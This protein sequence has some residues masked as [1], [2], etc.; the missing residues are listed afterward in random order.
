ML[1]MC[2][3]CSTSHNY[4]IRWNKALIFTSIISVAEFLRCNEKPIRRALKADG[5][6]KQTKI[7][8]YRYN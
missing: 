3:K 7:P 8:S 4:W 1:K 5:V 2:C 6:I